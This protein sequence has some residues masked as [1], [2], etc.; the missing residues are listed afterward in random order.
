MLNC[1]QFFNI[2]GKCSNINKLSGSQFSMIIRSKAPVRFEFG[3]GG[4]D[5]APFSEDYGGVVFNA[6]IDQYAFVTVTPRD[7]EEF[8]VESLDY[9]V[10]AHF[11]AGEGLEFSGELGLVKA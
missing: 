5:V 3:G 2:L 9:D 10:L 8:T 6:T 4:T 7:D 11:E 1:P